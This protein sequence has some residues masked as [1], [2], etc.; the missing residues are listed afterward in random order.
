MNLF[1]AQMHQM[2]MVH[3]LLKT[4]VADNTQ[5]I[6]ID[7]GD[8]SI[9]S[10][11]LSK[12]NGLDITTQ[13]NANNSLNDIDDAI[14]ILSSKQAD[15]GSYQNRIHHAIDSLMNINLIWLIQMEEF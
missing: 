4:R 14:P 2:Q 9:A 11:H 12:L 7:I 5:S 1:D 6:T 3:L 10:G 8:F 13:S 15:F